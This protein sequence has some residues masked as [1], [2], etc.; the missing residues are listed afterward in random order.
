MSGFSIPAD[1][2]PETIA[3]LTHANAT[4]D[5]PVRE[6]YGSLN[7]S[8]Y[9]SGRRSGLITPVTPEELRRYVACAAAA[10]IEFNYTLNF[11]SL[12]N[13]EYAGREEL[14]QFLE[15]L[16]GLGVRRFTVALPTVLDVFA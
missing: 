13:R 6:V 1:F 8:L 2:R 11:S 15:N 3:A 9:G 4:M 7:P 16:A 5:L 10:G 14:R 12:G